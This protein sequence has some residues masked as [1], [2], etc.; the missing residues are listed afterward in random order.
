M[1][2]ALVIF[3]F[4]ASIGVW[5]CIGGRPEDDID[6]QFKDGWK[7]AEDEEFD[8]ETFIQEVVAIPHPGPFGP[9]EGTTGQ[10]ENV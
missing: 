2:T 5:C 1:E 7:L 3:V 9:T 8:P 10:E 4:L 6:L